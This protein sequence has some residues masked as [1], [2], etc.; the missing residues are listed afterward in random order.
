MKAFVS[1]TVVALCALSGCDHSRQQIVGKRKASSGGSEVVWE[2]HENGTLSAGGTPGKYTLGDSRR[3]KIQTPSATFVHQL[4]F[5]G[6]DKMIWTE[7]N[8]T[9][10]E[11]TRVK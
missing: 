1:L 2:F 4:E 7:T 10:T 8:G 6:D 3:L 11:L 9:R 5:S